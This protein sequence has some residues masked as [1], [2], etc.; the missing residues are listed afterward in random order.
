MD[1]FYAGLPGTPFILKQRF[2]STD[3]MKKAFDMQEEYTDVFYGEY[4]IIDTINKS[5]PDNGKI[6]RRGYS[7]PEYIGQVVGPSGLFCDNI[8]IITRNSSKKVCYDSDIDKPITVCASGSGNWGDDSLDSEEEK[9][10]FAVYEFNETLEQ[11]KYKQ[12]YKIIVYD[13]YEN[14]SNEDGSYIPQVVATC[15]AGVY[16]VLESMQEYP[17]GQTVLKY[18]SSKDEILADED[19]NPIVKSWLENVSFDSDTGQLKFTGN[20]CNDT[21]NKVF[22]LKLL[23]NVRLDPDGTVHFLYTNEGAQGEAENPVEVDEP[24]NQALTWIKDVR[25]DK[26]KGQ[27]QIYFNNDKISPIIAENL[28]IFDSYS[29]PP[30]YF[31]EILSENDGF[32]VK[33]E[34]ITKDNFSEDSDYKTDPKVATDSISGKVFYPALTTSNPDE[35][36]P[37]YSY[38]PCYTNIPLEIEFEVSSIKRSYSADLLTKEAVKTGNLSESNGSLS[39]SESDESVYYYDSAGIQVV[40]ITDGSNT[41]EKFKAQILFNNFHLYEIDWPL[42]DGQPIEIIKDGITYRKISFEKMADG[43]T[44]SLTFGEDDGSF[45]YKFIGQERISGQFNFV[46]KVEENSLGYTAVTNTKNETSLSKTQNFRTPKEFFFFDKNDPNKYSFHLF[47]NYSY[48]ELT[49]L[50]KQDNENP[51]EEG[52]YYISP[53]LDEIY[54]G[55]EKV[56]NSDKI[57]YYQEKYYQIGE[58]GVV[59]ESSVEEGYPFDGKEES[60]WESCGV[61]KGYWKDLGKI[62]DGLTNDLPSLLANI[63]YTVEAPKETSSDVNILWR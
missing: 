56:E 51:A 43:E 45:S 24:V 41:G 37:F 8:R 17:N 54:K 40:K 34:D 48:P 4:C 31:E 47:A 62:S 52:I 11:E 10:S 61:E 32:Y 18:S 60:F 27:L 36:N 39:W 13:I 63:A 44:G 53:N 6:F 33:M 29:T 59:E 2:T 38:E 21:L 50:S 30:Y 3:A 42:A 58:N 23:K 5:H 25:L 46:K 15:F 49:L 22:F 16:D 55:I 28:A 7:D 14:V 57:F 19:D 35:N 9:L 1:S 12:E 20:G 26:N